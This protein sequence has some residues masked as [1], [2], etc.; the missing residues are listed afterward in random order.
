MWLSGQYR[1]VDLQ[2]D[3]PYL[4]DESGTVDYYTLGLG[5]RF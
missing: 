1:Y 3:A 2:D 4:E 5:L